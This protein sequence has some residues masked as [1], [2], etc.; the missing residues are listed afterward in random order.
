MVQ[1][2][3]LRGMRTF[4]TIWVAQLVSLVGSQLTGFA[5]GV[6]VY[7]ETRSVLMLALT[8]I[9]LQAPYVILSPL[10]GV[11]VD[12]WDRR[13]AMI[14]SDLGAGLAVLAAAMLYLSGLLRPWMVIPVNFVMA[15][16][17][18]LMWPAYTAA[19][20]L[21]VPREQYGRAN[22]FVQLGEALPQVAGPAIAGALYVA[23]KLGYLALVDFAT[24]AFAVFVMLALVRIPQPP[25]SADG[26]RGGG[27]LLEEMTFGWRYIAHRRGLLALLTY[28]LMLNFLSGI[29]QPL[30]VPLV[31]ENWDARVL[32]FLS[33]I[34]GVGM[35][36]GTL[37]MSAWGGGRRKIVTLLAAGIV[38]SLFL[39]AMGLRAYIPLLA[40]AGFG[41]MFAMPFMNASSQAI[42]QAKV[43]PDVQGRVFAIRRAIAWSTMIAAPLLA[44][45]L[46]D[47]VFKPAMSPGGALEP[48]LGPLLGSGASRG[49]GLMVTVLGLLA[50]IVSFLALG[51]RTIR[52][53]ETDLPDHVTQAVVSTTAAAGEP[54]S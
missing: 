6:W 51:N 43:A 4:L 40:V 52:N 49:I 7:D 36:T 16:F 31:L 26:H 10:A 41:F 38:E 21:L 23:V 20:T 50:A 17:H 1:H 53:V 48:L 46:A 45:P 47:R 19:V 30:F 27:R 33:T 29:L 25:A 8:Q 34:M 22:G 5:L 9:A 44:A 3:S 39:A 11:M 14:V 54:T 24:Y 42:W 15:A 2:S 13:T 35:L 12:R 37:V 28:F 18:S 32:G